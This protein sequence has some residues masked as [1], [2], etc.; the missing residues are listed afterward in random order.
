[1]ALF[2]IFTAIGLGLAL[3]HFTPPLAYYLY[4]K[5]R[6]LNKPWNVKRNPN[7]RPYNDNG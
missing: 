4:L 7:Y 2:D 6:W 5:R 1:M 3:I